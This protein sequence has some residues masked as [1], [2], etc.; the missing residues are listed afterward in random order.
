MPSDLNCNISSSLGVRPAGPHSHVG[1]FC[2]VNVIPRMHILLVTFFRRTL[3]VHHL[4]RV[5][6]QRSRAISLR[7]GHWSKHL[8][9]SNPFSFSLPSTSHIF[10][11]W[12]LQLRLWAARCHV[13]LHTRAK[14][15]HCCQPSTPVPNMLSHHRGP[16]EALPCVLA[17]KTLSPAP[18]CS[19]GAGR[20]HLSPGQ[21][22]NPEGSQRPRSQGLCGGA[23]PGQR[24]HVRRR[25]QMS[26]QM[27]QTLLLTLSGAGTAGHPLVPR[28]F[29]GGPYFHHSVPASLVVKYLEL[30]PWREVLFTSRL[31]MRE[32]GLPWRGW[33]TGPGSHRKK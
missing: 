32:G 28:H 20:G 1:H 23:G 13:S 12:K 2:K 18:G 22:L 17:S 16:P 6:S 25:P 33:E 10:F 21:L 8:A 3:T 26:S 15:G 4:Y 9:Y 14:L 19:L 24:G 31:Q 11:V 27:S 5:R 29:P 7:A 30:H